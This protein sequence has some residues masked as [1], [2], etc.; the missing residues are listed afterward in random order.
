MTDRV[1]AATGLHL[2]SS[3]AA[4]V[5]RVAKSSY[6]PMN[7]PAREGSKRRAWSRWD[8]PGRTVYA[9]DSPETAFIEALAWAHD[10]AASRNRAI[11][12]TA[13]LFGISP[14]AARELVEADWLK[15]G[16]MQPG[17][18]P[19]VWR[20]GRRVYRLTFPEGWWVDVMSSGTLSAISAGLEDALLKRGISGTL[21]LSEVTSNDRKLTTRIATWLREEVTL[22]DG[23][24]PLGIRFTSKYGRSGEADGTSWAYWMRAIDAGL[25]VE[26]VGVD[27]GEPINLTDAALKRA[28]RFHRIDSR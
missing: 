28:L 4:P 22:A 10:E 17:W 2:V 7:P 8:T 12:K 18:L 16:N 15:A 20:D 14:R 24:Q 26:Q 1:D 6:G 27:S 25:S 11:R 13:D 5:Y 9:S 3:P 19:S 23:T 21:T